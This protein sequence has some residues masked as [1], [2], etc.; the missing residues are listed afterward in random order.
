M[1]R[2]PSFADVYCELTD[3]YRAVERHQLSGRPETLAGS[4]CPRAPDM[5]DAERR[6]VSF[7]SYYE[8]MALYLN[9]GEGRDE[10]ENEDEDQGEEGDI[11]RTIMTIKRD[12]VLDRDSNGDG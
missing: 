1:V 3:L 12:V 6:V 9:W 10:D 4:P 5:A 7:Q 2:V 11:E 8:S